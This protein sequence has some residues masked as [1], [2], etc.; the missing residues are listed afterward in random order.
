MP[1]RIDKP[2]AEGKPSVL[3]PIIP[4]VPGDATA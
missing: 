3:K 2:K 1:A 4:T